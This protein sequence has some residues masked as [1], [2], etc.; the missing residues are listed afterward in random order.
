MSVE[1]QDPSL[2]QNIASSTRPQRAN[3]P[4]LVCFS[5][6]SQLLSTKTL[7]PVCVIWPMW[8]SHG[9][10][11]TRAWQVNH[12]AICEDAIMN[13]STDQSHFPQ[14]SLESSSVLYGGWNASFQLRSSSGLQTFKMS[15][16][17]NVSV[18]RTVCKRLWYL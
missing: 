8:P 7:W 6:C 5:R 16:G 3:K 12:T 15:L 1:F 14:Y 4:G 9:V 2:K 17:V 13:P 11:L 18:T 10:E